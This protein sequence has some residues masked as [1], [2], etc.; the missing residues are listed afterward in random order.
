[1]LHLP[2]QVLTALI[3]LDESLTVWRQRHAL[4]AHRML[5]RQTGSAGSSHT[6][7]D[8]TAKRYKAFKDLFDVST[9]LLP[10]SALPPLPP[11][12]SS[13]LDFRAAE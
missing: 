8:E 2:F 1:M 9:Y 3:E 7:L 4:M 10:R 13:R 6:Y 11:A 5:G 12:L